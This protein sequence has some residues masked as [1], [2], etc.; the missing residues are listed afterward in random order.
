MRFSKENIFILFLFCLILLSGCATGS[1]IVT[2]TKREPIKSENVKIYLE[3]PQKFE[4]IGLVNASSDAGFTEQGSIDYA[5]AEL[6]KQAAK[7]G[8]NGVI[9]TT[10]GDEVYSMYSSGIIFPVS[11]KTISGKAIFVFE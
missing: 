4:V 9:I 7:L 11:V 6:K 10:T 3:A 1:A 5:I 8:A 2:G